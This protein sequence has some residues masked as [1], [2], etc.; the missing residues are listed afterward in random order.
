MNGFETAYPTSATPDQV[1]ASQYQCTK[2]ACNVDTLLALEI[3]QHEQMYYPV[4]IND[5]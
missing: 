1:M 4:L 2:F 5:R 3:P